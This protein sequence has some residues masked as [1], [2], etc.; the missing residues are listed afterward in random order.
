MAEDPN[1]KF[2]EDDKGRLL[3]NTGFIIA[4]QS[5]RTQEMFD[6]WES[7]PTGDRYPG[8]DHWLKEWAH[9]QAAFGYYLRYDY[10]GPDELRTIPC[11][12]GNGAPFIGNDK[13]RGIFI[14]HHWNDKDRTIQNLYDSILNLFIQRLHRQFHDGIDRY[15]LDAKR[16]KTVIWK[17]LNEAIERGKIHYLP[18][19]E[20]VG[21]GL[22]DVQK[23]VNLFGFLHRVQAPGRMLR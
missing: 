1:E 17:W 20:I 2:N 9:E 8:C 16:A 4:Q 12:Q 15:F 10:N 14:S 18:K 6:N 13:C 11:D 19:P 21:G 23:A 5:N 22:E 7:C 3:W